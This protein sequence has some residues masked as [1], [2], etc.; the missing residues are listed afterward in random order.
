MEENIKNK[1]ITVVGLGYVGLPLA[2]LIAYKGLNVRGYDIDSRKLEAI[3]QKKVEVKDSFVSTIFNQV[4]FEVDTVLKSSDIYIICVPTPVDEKNHPDLTPLVGAVNAVAKVLQDDQLVVIE[5]TVYPGMSE[6]T[7][8]PI[9]NKTGKRYMLAHCPERINPGDTRWN[10]NNIPRVVGGLDERSTQMAREFYSSIVDANV[11]PLSNIRN[12]EATKILEN[13]FRDVNTALVN[14]MAQSFYRMGIDIKEVLDAASTKP[15][16][17]LPH[18]P[19]V[20]VGGHCIAVDPYYMIEKGRVAG[21][22]HDLLRLARRINSNMPIYTVNLLQ[23]TFNSLGL[24]IKGRTVGVYGLSYK[25]EV[26]D[27]RESPSYE[28]IKRLK[29]LKEADV[30]V[31]DPYVPEQSTVSTA[32]EL[33]ARSDAIIICTAH[34]E[35]KNIDYTS[36]KAGNLKV[37]LD[38]RNCLDKQKIEGLGLVYKGIGR[39]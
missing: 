17:F 8:E 1:H 6:E 39:G 11:M 10:V 22:D 19:G 20:G 14:E 36:F 21:F 28:V 34:N 16:S 4:N 33:L 13:I 31:Y 5:S 24:S 12:A 3:R 30:L 7:V 29:N 25:P 38:G 9:L 23:N 37:V 27:T 18:Y 15:F 35:I 2:S 26:S 32:D